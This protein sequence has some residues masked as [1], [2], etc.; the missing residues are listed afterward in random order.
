V[1]GHQYPPGSQLKDNHEKKLYELL[2]GRPTTVKHFIDFRIKCYIK[3]DEDNL[4]KFDYRSDEGIFLGYSPNK[5]DY[6]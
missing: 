4:G 2:F 1:G 5:K 6:K 3:R